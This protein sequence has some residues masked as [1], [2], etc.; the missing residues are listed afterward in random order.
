MAVIQV[1]SRDHP[2]LTLSEVAR[3][4]G[5]TRATC[6][7]ILLTL[8]KLGHVRS[9]GRSFM[10]TP[11]VLT[12]GWA[13]LTSLNLSELAQPLMEDLVERTARV[14]LGGDARPARRRLR[15]PGADAPDHDDLARRRRAPARARDVDGA[16]PARRA[17][18]RRARGVPRGD[19][20]RALHRAHDH[21]PRRAAGGD[22]RRRARRAGRSS[23][24]SSRPGSARSRRRSTGRTRG[25]S[26]RSTPRRPRSGCRSRS[27]AA[28]SSPRCSRRPS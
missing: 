20:A 24:R 15:R 6:R 2:A 1:F 23:T 17:P 16:R 26:R 7:R 9:D 8:E 27:S 19:A 12:L 14:V 10:L 21:R 13:Y 3:L 25:R 5:F 22:R 11:R 28:A 18:R 4:T